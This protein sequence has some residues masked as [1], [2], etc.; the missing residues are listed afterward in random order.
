M[1]EDQNTT[2]KKKVYYRRAKWPDQSRETLENILKNVHA[3]LPTVGHRTFDTL[4]GELRGVKFKSEDKG[5]FLHVASYTPDQPTSAIDKDRMVPSSMVTAE[6]APIGKDFLDGDIFLLIRDNHVIL[7]PSGVRET[8]A[9]K[10]FYHVLKSQYQD[11]AVNLVLD[12]VA[13]V[14]KL[15]M[16]RIEGVKELRLAASLYDA[17]VHRINAQAVKSG[18]LYSIANDFKSIFSKDQVLRDISELE[19]LNITLSLKFDGNEGRKKHAEPNFG[20][21]GRERLI[22]T[23]EMILNEN[24]DDGFVIVTGENNTITAEEVRISDNLDIKSLGKSINCSDAW[25][26]LVEYYDKL[27]TDGNL[28]Q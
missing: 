10:Y 22:R 26:K 16:I 28:S 18:L 15:K 7:C 27:E 23:A 24:D 21:V 3:Q 2:K 1:S 9:N 5:I 20:A 13:N 19:N 8:I 12:K 11:I 6:P 4:S 14:N 25:E 17:S